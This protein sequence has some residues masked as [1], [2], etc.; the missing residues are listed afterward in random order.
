MI[1]AQIY[2]RNEKKTTTNIHTSQ[3]SIHGKRNKQF[4]VCDANEAEKNYQRNQTC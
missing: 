1:K 4:W 3:Q 2:A